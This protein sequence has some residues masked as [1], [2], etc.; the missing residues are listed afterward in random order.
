MSQTLQ[1]KISNYGSFKDS[2]K[3]P[4][5]RW[6]TYPAGYSYKLVHAKINEYGLNSNS[7]VLDPFLGSGTTTLASMSV[8]VNSIG[9][10]AHKF[11]ANV[12]RTKCIRYE[13]HYDELTEAYKH[14]QKS[15]KTSKTSNID[16]KFPALIYK[17][18]EK[19]NLGNL[20]M[21][22]DIVFNMDGVKKDFFTLALI[23]T[24]RHASTAGTGW[25]YIAPSKY[26]NKKIHVDAITKFYEQCSMMLNDINLLNRP[27]SKTKIHIAD[28]TKKIKLIHDDSVDLAITSPPYLNNYDYADRTRMETYFLGIYKNW[29][30]ISKDVRDKLM[31]S[32]TTQV[33]KTRM[34]GLFEMSTVMELSPPIHKIITEAINLM[35]VKK[36]EKAGKKNYDMMTAGYF[37]GIANTMINVFNATC[38][39]GHFVLVLGDSAPYGIH[40]ATDVLIARLG[41]AV[42]FK[43]S[44]VTPI[45]KRGDKW[46]NNPQR[47]HV[48]L[49][50]S[51]VVLDK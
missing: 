12:A 16:S 32:A 29:G 5:H 43:K 42:G 41:C 17:C 49:R 50:E 36:T 51:I 37:E 40:V 27:K 8:G 9:I 25:P 11:V 15:I 24:L 22:R 30:D 44:N 6:F 3:E 31:I 7:V 13:N 20:T 4:I 10:E 33:N 26:A 19:K 46:K 48:K 1:S 38:K 28:S 18:F 39:G 47:H 34:N 14:L 45:R 2:K 21:I 35:A 23:S